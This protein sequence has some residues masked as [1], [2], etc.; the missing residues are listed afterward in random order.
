MGPD[1]DGVGHD[2]ARQRE[3]RLNASIAADAALRGLSV[4]IEL[5]ERRPSRMARLL[6]CVPDTVSRERV[7]SAA[8]GLLVDQGLADHRLDSRLIVDH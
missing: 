7:I 4:W 8:R 2:L 6:G 5:G 3:D 1:V